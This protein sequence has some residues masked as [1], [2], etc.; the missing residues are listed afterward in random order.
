V[1]AAAL[2]VPPPPT[3]EDA[4][5]IEAARLLRAGGGV[6][7]LD[8]R[9]LREDALLLAHRIAAHTGARLLSPTSVV[10]T[11]RGPGRPA[12]TRIPYVVDVAQAELADVASLIL[13]GSIRPAT[14][15]AYPGKRGTPEPAD[16]ILHSLAAP[17]DDL[18][19]ALARLCDV[20]GAPPVALPDHGPLPAMPTGKPTSATFAQML[21]HVMPE[22]TII[23]DEGISF[24]YQLAANTRAAPRHDWLQL[25]G[26]AIGDGL[27]MAT[28]AAIGA[29]GRRVITLQADGSALYTIQALWTQAREKLDVTT[30]IFSNRSYAILLGEFANVGVE[31]PPGVNAQAMMQ[32]DRPAIDWLKLSESFGVEAA[33]AETL[34]ACADLIRSSNRRSGPF[35]IELVIA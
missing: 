32:F 15:F 23:V 7:L 6:L 33:R 3:V 16:A 1:P 4:A 34:E 27:P 28:G 25:T 13:V 21:S 14:F 5:V 31:G 12:V 35:L 20:L 8:G 9:A 19:D 30:I 24:G 11:E 29:P 17:G 18:V 2:N 26:G 22:D 10:R